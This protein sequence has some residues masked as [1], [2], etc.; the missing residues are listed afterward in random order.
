MKSS[1]LLPPVVSHI[2][3]AYESRQLKLTLHAPRL[4]PELLR[5]VT[6]G[7]VQVGL[8]EPI[9]GFPLLLLELASAGSL[10]VGLNLRAGLPKAHCR[11]A[12]LLGC[13]LGLQLQLTD[14][15]LGRPA[16][17]QALALPPA[18]SAE[19]RRKLAQQVTQYRDAGTVAGTYQLLH[20]WRSDP[21]R[22]RDV[23]HYQVYPIEGERGSGEKM[24]NW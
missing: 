10:E 15:R 13:K 6:D 1:P 19:V 24:V 23:L 21:S 11:N 17:S 14:A 9:A 18:F 12:W 7:S 2:H 4:T 20:T 22:Q 8:A 3:V 5:G 16:T